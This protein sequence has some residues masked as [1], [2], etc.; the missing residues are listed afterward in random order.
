MEAD[1]EAL[2]LEAEQRRPYVKMEA[3]S[4]DGAAGN[5]GRRSDREI[6]DLLTR[7]ANEALSDIIEGDRHG[8][9]SA[10]SKESVHPGPVRRPEPKGDTHVAE[11]LAP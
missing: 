6:D 7:A 9:A 11:S 2:A 8:L 5:P 4:L 10:E 1:D 3:A